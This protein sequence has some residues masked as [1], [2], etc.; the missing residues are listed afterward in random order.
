MP[1]HISSLSYI[2]TVMPHHT[3]SL[4]YHITVIRP[5][6]SCYHVLS[7]VPYPLVVVVSFCHNQ[8]LHS[9]TSF[10]TAHWDTLLT[11]FPPR[12]IGQT[13][14]GS[15]RVI[16]PV[17]TSRFLDSRRA[18]RE[19]RVRS[20]L[21]NG[22]F[23]ASPQKTS[24]DNSKAAPRPQDNT[25]RTQA[26]KVD[27]AARTQAR[28][29]A[30]PQALNKAAPEKASTSQVR[31][32]ALRQPARPQAATRT[33]PEKASKVG[34][35]AGSGPRARANKTSMCAKVSGGD[36]ALASAAP[37]PKAVAKH[38]SPSP[39]PAERLTRPNR[40]A[41]L[42]SSAPSTLPSGEQLSTKTR[43]G[44]G[45]VAAAPAA[46][47]P[48][49]KS[50]QPSPVD[51]SSLPAGVYE[52]VRREG[53]D[54]PAYNLKRVSWKFTG[55]YENIFSPPQGRVII[56]PEPEE[57]VGVNR[58]ALR[59]SRT[60]RYERL[61]T[62]P[63]YKECARPRCRPMAP[64]MP[65]PPPDQSAC[66]PERSETRLTSA[67]P[68]AKKA[69]P[70]ERKVS[71]SSDRSRSL[72]LRHRS[73]SDDR[74]KP[75]HRS[76]A[77]ARSALRTGSKRM[78]KQHVVRFDDNVRER[79]VRRWMTECYSDYRQS[80]G[81]IVMWCPDTNWN[82]DP[83]HPS[84]NAHI[85]TWSK[86]PEEWNH[87]RNHLPG[88]FCFAGESPILGNV[89]ACAPHLRQLDWE[90]TCPYQPYK[91]AVTRD[92]GAQGECTCES[93]GP[94]D[95]PRKIYRKRLDL[96]LSSATYRGPLDGKRAILK[97][98]LAGMDWAGGVAVFPRGQ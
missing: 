97:F 8:L 52:K 81:A 92:L 29:Q 91:L 79:I 58:T 25:G 37:K 76:A 23:G 40:A 33:V 64:S 3:S 82:P 47:E 77:P 74:R 38:I 14:P 62:T 56:S 88:T 72:H 4:S 49:G 35:L 59:V 16:R 61:Y 84:D 32:Q 1:P 87:H 90:N 95:C 48:K 39:K 98:V 67:G 55:G 36:I 93:S 65:V 89:S 83:E 96:A 73:E 2:I 20:W 19:S 86:H 57:E 70:S 28:R 54:G 63:R 34:P 22:T 78:A 17:Q 31:S 18:E 6:L 42:P 21:A 7:L 30:R 66:W 12:H 71:G 85:R 68:V 5:T 27:T 10:T 94:F 43:R 75:A 13:S 26:S 51:D 15:S 11:L 69:A 44:A 45:V 60:P 9:F 24:V 53:S 80:A 50:A 46:A 41:K